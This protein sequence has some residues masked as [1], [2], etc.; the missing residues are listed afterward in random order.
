[1]CSLRP[2]RQ[3][4]RLP[5]LYN[6]SGRYA[7]GMVYRGTF[8]LVAVYVDQPCHHPCDV[9]VAT[10]F[11]LCRDVS[12]SFGFPSILPAQSTCIGVR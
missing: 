4:G 7:R 8:V 10:S 11:T 12:K 5:Q 2:A 3:P 1:M 9:L 6:N